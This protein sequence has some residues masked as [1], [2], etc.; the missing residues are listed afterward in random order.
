MKNPF[1]FTNS[2][3]QLGGNFFDFTIPEKISNPQLIIKNTQLIN[4]LQ[5]DEIDNEELT[6]YLSGNKVSQKAIAAV[7][8]G[9]QFGSFNPQLGDGRAALLGEIKQDKTVDIQLKGSGKTKYSRG[10]DGKLALGPAIREYL[11]SEYMFY[12]GVASSRSLAL[13]KG[14]NQVMRE[15]PLTG[16][17]LTRVLASNI[18]IGTFEYFASRGEVENIKKLADYAINRHYPEIENSENKYL[19]FLRLVAKNQAKL[20]AKMM[21]LGFIHGVLNTDNTTISGEIID[22]GPC[23][24]MDAYSSNKV[25]SSIDRGSRY[26]YNNQAN[27]VGWNLSSLAYCLSS[28]VED[29]KEENQQVFSDYA[30]EFDKNYN[31]IMANKLGFYYQ[32]GDEK[33]IDEVFKLMQKY[34]LDF[35]NFFSELKADKA[36]NLGDDFN[37]WLNSWQQR[38]SQE[39][40]NIT[41]LMVK[42]N[43][44][45]IPRNH[46]IERIIT[47]AY[48]G[49][50]TEFYE[51]TEILQDP[52]TVS[53]ESLKYSV[54]P[55]IDEVV[56]ATF[57]GT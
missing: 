48:E 51:F 31:N 10:G 39:K 52:F 34:S 36:Y 56:N 33:I 13:I 6:N 16:A 43:P 24:F 14:D 50:F 21:G 30:L 27:I 5:I 45:F 17:V 18:R 25:F 49:D 9:H 20:V 57:C 7:Y 46:I 54:E 12:A 22:Y 1:N 26:A 35:T 41:D 40:H 4:K 38:L 8:A 55:K 47:N 23:A 19:E 53:K 29:S 3:Q 2:Y 15:K 32:N 42:S 37:I 11:V 44:V 28:L